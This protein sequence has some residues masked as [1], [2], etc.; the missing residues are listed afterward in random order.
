MD[1]CIHIA[2]HEILGKISVLCRNLKSLKSK[3][4]HQDPRLRVTGYHGL[5]ITRLQPSDGGDYSCQVSENL[6]PAEI[7][8]IVSPCFVQ[9]LPGLLNSIS[10][11]LS[12]LTTW[13]LYRRSPTD[14]RFKNKD[15]KSLKVRLA[16]L[17]QFFLED[18]WLYEFRVTLSG[19]WA[20]KVAETTIRGWPNTGSSPC[21]L[22][23]PFLLVFRWRPFSLVFFG[24]VQVTEGE[25][26][27]LRC[28]A[29]GVPN[30]LIRFHIHTFPKVWA[31]PEK[32]SDGLQVTAWS[33]SFS[34][35]FIHLPV[36]VWAHQ[37]KIRWSG[38]SGLPLGR[39]LSLS[40]SP[41]RSA[42]GAY[43]C[44]ARWKKW[45]N[46]LKPFW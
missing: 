33:W 29:S 10:L 5:V 12:R 2:S 26:V 28:S 3:L 18:L 22:M 24:F 21:C 36:S 34:F 44:T 42:G 15:E 46:P 25:S 37:E 40:L 14:Y 39:G 8:P 16:G 27:T 41:A 13:V 19:A 45:T 38:P 23:S 9:A 32:K 31:H 11:N 17:K 30:P 20:A 7:V 35:I 1:S 4:S 6:N 43:T